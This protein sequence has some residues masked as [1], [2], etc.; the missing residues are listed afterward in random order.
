MLKPEATLEGFLA[1]SV[2]C[3]LYLF[4]TCMYLLDTEW[5]KQ[6]P[7]TISLVPFDRESTVT[8]T[9]QFWENSMRSTRYID[10]DGKV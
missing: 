8:A 3:F 10:F 6:A 4:Y 5:I 7:L 2:T 1:G 9:G